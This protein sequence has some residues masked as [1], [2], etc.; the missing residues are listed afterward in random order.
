MSI[1]IFCTKRNVQS[2]FLL[3]KYKEIMQNFSFIY[4]IYVE[5]VK[6]YCICYHKLFQQSKAISYF[7]FFFLR[8]FEK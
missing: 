3:F 2:L 5:S 8:I 7:F 4:N 1:Y 6:I